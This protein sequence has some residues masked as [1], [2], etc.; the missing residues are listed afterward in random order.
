MNSRI[1][2]ITLVSI[3]FFGT[4]WHTQ[5]L[6]NTRFKLIIVHS[7]PPHGTTPGTQMTSHQTPFN[8]KIP[9]LWSSS[10]RTSRH[11]NIIVSRLRNTSISYSDSTLHPHVGT[12]MQTKYNFPSFLSMPIFLKSQKILLCP[13]SPLFV[14]SLQQL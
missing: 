9:T 1:Q 8:K 6:M 4:Q 13:I 12:G 2:E 7:S 14:G 11:E 10:N 3:C 5:I